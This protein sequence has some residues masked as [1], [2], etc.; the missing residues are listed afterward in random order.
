MKEIYL[1]IARDM[2]SDW[3][4]IEGAYTNRGDATAARERSQNLWG[5]GT[6]LNPATYSVTV[7][8]INL[9]GE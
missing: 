5:K 7:R 3:S 8:S 4:C 9:I 2:H 1:V 6:P